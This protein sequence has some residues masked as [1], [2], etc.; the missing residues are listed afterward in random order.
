MTAPNYNLE[1]GN[2][3]KLMKLFC[4]I[5]IKQPNLGF[6]AFVGALFVDVDDDDAEV[7]I[8]FGADVT[9]GDVGG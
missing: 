7:D 8:F 6:F 5:F 3:K 9:G 1:K 2:L 4:P